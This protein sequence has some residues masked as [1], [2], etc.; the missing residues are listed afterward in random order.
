LDCQLKGASRRHCLAAL[1][2]ALGLCL[3]LSVL[4]RQIARSLNAQRAAQKRTLPMPSSAAQQL[5]QTGLSLRG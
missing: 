2:K 4:Q 3:P 5:H 1:L